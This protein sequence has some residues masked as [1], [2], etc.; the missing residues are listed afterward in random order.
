MATDIRLDVTNKEIILESTQLIFTVQEIGSKVKELLQE[1]PN[2]DDGAA[3][4]WSGFDSLPGGAKTGIV[5]QLLDGW[6]LR[7]DP[8]VSDTRVQITQGIILGT[9]GGDPLG[10][11]ANVSYS[12]AE[13]TV[14]AL[15]PGPGGLTAQ[16]V[17]DSMK[18]APSVGAFAVGSIDDKIDELYESNRGRWKIDTAT[19]EMI[20][21][22][23]DNT[24]ELFRM[25]LFDSAGVPST[26]NVFER[27]KK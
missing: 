11:A 24:T 12:I 26:V 2:I 25:E 20:F 9:G 13:Y 19:N 23:S 1:A 7:A 21:F 8:Q 14:S 17:R 3:F 18:L 27:T 5:M 4:T 6:I 22:K 10:T 15:L 16:Q